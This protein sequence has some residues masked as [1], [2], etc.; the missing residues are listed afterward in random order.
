MR[1]Y[2]E[3]AKPRITVMVMATTGLGYLLSGRKADALLWWTMI[4][5]GLVGAACGALNQLIERGPDALMRRT[6]SRPLPTGRLNSTQSLSFGVALAASGLALLALKSGLLA[7]AVTAFTL[8]S[9]VLAYTPLKRVTPHATWIGA[10]AGATPPLVGWAA[11]QG[12][13]PVQAWVLFAIQFLWQI[14]HFLAIFW[15]HRKDYEKAG[16]RVMPVVDPRGGLTAAQ[17]ALHS[18]TVLPASLAPSL[19]GMAGPGYGLGALLLGTAYL[20]LGMKAS[21]T[22]EAVDTRRLFLASLAYLP[23]L[24]GMLLIGGA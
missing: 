24:F 23:M 8:I 21:W 5:A 16:F 15:L 10:A 11:A 9:Y 14:P 19:C 17:I 20:G 6:Q 18:F 3:L 12:A 4:G 2:L 13:L 7:A 22:L 1:A